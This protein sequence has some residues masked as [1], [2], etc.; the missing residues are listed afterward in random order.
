M[1]KILYGSVAL[2][3]GFCPKCNDTSFCDSEMQ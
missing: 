2:L 3:H 1:T